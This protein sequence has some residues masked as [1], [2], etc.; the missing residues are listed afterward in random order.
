MGRDWGQ[1]ERMVTDSCWLVFTTRLGGE[2]VFVLLVRLQEDPVRYRDILEFI[3]LCLC[4][5]F[6]G[7]YKVMSQGRDEFERIVKQLYKLLSSRRKLNTQVCFIWIL[8]GSLVV[9]N[10]A[11]KFLCAVCLWGSI[12]LA[13]IFG[14]YHHQLNNQTQDVL[15]QLGELLK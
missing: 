3:Y 13:T 2:K 11:S 7:R 4:L 6:E 14:L 8:V 10:Y 15:R 9:I 1:S 12:L 5:G